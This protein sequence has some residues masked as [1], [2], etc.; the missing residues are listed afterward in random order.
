MAH[1]WQCGDTFELSESGA[2]QNPDL[3]NHLFFIISYAEEYP[4]KVV[5]V[6]ITTRYNLIGEDHTCLVE[7]NDHPSWVEHTSYVRYNE[8]RI[9]S[10][11]S[12]N[13]L[14]DTDLI[15]KRNPAN[16]DLLVRLLDGAF[17]SQH[18]PTGVLDVLRQQELE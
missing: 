13:V 1:V 6:N 5:I 18:T 2:Q 11:D 15:T 9:T 16:H 14:Q 8:A 4:D 10:V 12:L 7:H 3:N 17:E